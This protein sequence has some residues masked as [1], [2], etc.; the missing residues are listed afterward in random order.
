M[1]TLLPVCV[2]FPK[3]ETSQAQLAS[4]RD[5]MTPN[6]GGRGARGPIPAREAEAAR[7]RRTRRA[8]GD[9]QGCEVRPVAAT[10]RGACPHWFHRRRWC[11]SR[12]LPASLP[13][14]AVTAA[15][16][17]NLWR[18]QPTDSAR[19]TAAACGDVPRR[20]MVGRWGDD[21]PQY[22]LREDLCELGLM[23]GQSGIQRD[24]TLH[25]TVWRLFTILCVNNER[26]GRL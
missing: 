1:S 16:Q 14:S 18:L 17:T 11:Q 12:P 23:S 20:P 15:R 4:L 22:W 3:F 13:A 7:W 2:F 24:G 9:Q 5:H 6:C 19:M 25:E 10:S 21:R 26:R 8:G